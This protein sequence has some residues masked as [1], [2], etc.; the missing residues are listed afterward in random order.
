MKNS[1]YKIDIE[2]H[3]LGSRIKAHYLK[4]VISFL[5]PQRWQTVSSVPQTNPGSPATEGALQ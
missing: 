4:E 2:I 1:S 5:W 3:T